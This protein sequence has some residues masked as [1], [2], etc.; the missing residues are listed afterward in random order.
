MRF[1][2]QI[3]PL[4]NRSILA[5]IKY[6]QYLLEV[7]LKLDV[8]GTCKIHEK[9]SS[10]D[11]ICWNS[12]VAIIL[13]W[14]KYYAMYSLFSLWAFIKETR[15]GGKLYWFMSVAFKFLFIFISWQIS[16]TQAN[17]MKTIATL[18]FKKVWCL[19]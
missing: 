15:K 12:L 3:H 19:P 8:L 5:N 14:E 6:K 18:S 7:W 11:C 9:V 4:K 13:V 2:F 16:S 1:L 10:V 17:M